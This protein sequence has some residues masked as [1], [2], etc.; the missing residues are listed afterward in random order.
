MCCSPWG[1]RVGWVSDWT[2]WVTRSEEYISTCFLMQEIMW[3][4]RQ[5]VMI[6]DIKCVRCTRCFLFLPLATG[7]IGNIVVIPGM[8]FSELF[9]FFVS[10]SFHLLLV[11]RAKPYDYVLVFRLQIIL[12]SIISLYTQKRPVRQVDR[13]YPNVKIVLGAWSPWP[14]SPAVYGS[15]QRT[16]SWSR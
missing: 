16:E 13:Y 14:T 7:W 12:K 6:K 15:G 5:Q 10:S 8:C 11:I 3:E 1:C 4:R 9:L 2:D